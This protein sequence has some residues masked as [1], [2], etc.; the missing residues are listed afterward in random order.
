MTAARNLDKRANSD[1]INRWAKLQQSVAEGKTLVSP[2]QLN[3][4]I[5]PDPLKRTSAP[6]LA[7][8]LDS[9]D[10]LSGHQ[11]S[12]FPT[13]VSALTGAE[14][15]ITD[16]RNAQRLGHGDEGNNDIVATE[17]GNSVE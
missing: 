15:V 9:L 16:E 7:H 17:G 6:A 8:Q 11:F 5:A 1:V 12:S 14:S 10:Y 4:A 3:A 2:E 13:R